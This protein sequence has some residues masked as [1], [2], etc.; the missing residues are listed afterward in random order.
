M[1]SL[2]RET[3]DAIRQ[4][5]VRRTVRPLSSRFMPSTSESQDVMEDIDSR[6]NDVL[7][8]LDELNEQ[9]EFLLNECRPTA[10]EQESVESPISESAGLAAH[11][12]LGDP[13][14]P[15]SQSPAAA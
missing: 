10:T 11:L 15:I 7:A 6:Q 13:A 14:A 12:S 8:R 1:A 9:I 2:F 5:C 4:D 3:T